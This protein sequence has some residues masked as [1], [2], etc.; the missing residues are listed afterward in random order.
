M[1]CTKCGKSLADDAK[2]CSGCGAAVKSEPAP[3]P[4]VAESTP[5]AVEPIPAPVV[6][7]PV[8]APVVAE[9]TPVAVE[10]APASVA[11]EPTPEPVVTEPVPTPAEPIP[12]PAPLPETFNEAVQTATPKKKKGKVGVIITCSALALVGAAAAVGYFCFSNQ[13]MRLIKG[14]KGYAREISEKSYT[15]YIFDGAEIDFD[16]FDSSIAL[17]LENQKLEDSGNFSDTDDLKAIL[18][19]A[20]LK[21]ILDMYGDS[22]LKL[23]ANAELK[24][25]LSLSLG[26]NDSFSTILDLV[27]GSEYIVTAQNG[28]NCEKYNYSFVFDGEEFISA[29]QYRSESLSAVTLPEI[30]DE[31]FYISYENDEKFPTEE[32]K[33]IRGEI[34]TIIEK[35]YD[36][37][38]FIYTDGEFNVAGNTINGTE[39]K[40]VFSQELCNIIYNEINDLLENDETLKGWFSEQDNE[41]IENEESEKLEAELSFCTYIAPHSEIIGKKII[42]KD[43]SEENDSIAI[44]YIKN[45]D[46]TRFVL[47]SEDGGQL[48]VISV[49]DTVSDSFNTTDVINTEITY[50]EDKDS[51]P[52]VL[53]L[54]CENPQKIHYQGETING[55][56][57]TL[58][59]SDKD[60]LF[61]AYFIGS[62]AA[63][64][65]VTDNMTEDFSSTMMISALKGLKIK[66]SVTGDENK[67]NA[68]FGIYSSSLLELSFTAEL[69]PYSAAETAV[70][71]DTTNAIDLSEEMDEK[72]ENQLKMSIS[73]KL[74]EKI[75]ANEKLYKIAEQMKLTEDLEEQLEEMSR[76][77][78]MLENYSG[79]TSSSKYDA[80]E[81]AEH[82]YNEFESNFWDAYINLDESELEEYPI[83]NSTKIITDV[84]T[85]KLYYDENGVQI[86]D[87][88]GFGFVDFAALVNDSEEYRSLYCELTFDFSRALEKGASYYDYDSF[89]VLTGVCAVYTDNPSNI[90]SVLPNTYNY[91]DG[92]FEWGGEENYIS[93]FVVGTYP[94][95]DEGTSTYLEEEEK[96]NSRKETLDNYALT[97]AKAVTTY[98]RDNPDLLD[99]I[100]D[101]S[102]FV[103]LDSND[104]SV[105]IGVNGD[106]KSSYTIA[107]MFKKSDISEY[108]TEK[109]KNK[110]FGGA[111]IQLHFMSKD[112]LL[113]IYTDYMDEAPDLPENQQMILIGT[114]AV[115]PNSGIDYLDLNIPKYYDYVFGYSVS[116][117]YNGNYSYLPMEG[118]FYIDG[119]NYIPFGS[120]CSSINSPFRSVYDYY[121]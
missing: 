74:L 79:Y 49:A 24:A 6:I 118:K 88:G 81:A 48:S 111:E 17:A 112:A 40:I 63:N 41:N 29:E 28:E 70:M 11:T 9:S 101:E 91:M 13:I 14:D 52:L 38:E 87:D 104:W 26:T 4:V 34:C 27:N 119:D 92:V 22:Q 100:T 16:K 59:L 80:R 47:D 105:K 51:L 75:K 10:P 33:R 3:I 120:W 8:P 89:P 113:T 62:S 30:T 102:F 96:F 109:L 115:E 31:I 76:A 121:E 117:S 39:I 116:W 53:D 12:T 107:N 61:S 42:V 25:L 72:V 36:E 5:V 82:I 83:L 32:V 103:V 94:T 57:Y 95:L 68:D 56:S 65:E 110:D 43:L 58:S 1:F 20:P 46:E 67:L 71:P 73:K 78:K 108:L 98:L 23:G 54:R 93:G 99:D 7:E 97:V 2:F 66:W 85:I 64:D 106:N 55:G 86:I 19:T 90:P 21:T 69:T 50:L 114:A 35:Y 84:L 15:E 37:A 60:K 77:E 18:K 44:G 45:D